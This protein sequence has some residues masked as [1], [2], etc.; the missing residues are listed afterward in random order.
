MA[1]AASRRRL[2]SLLPRSHPS[3]PRLPARSLTSTTR[4]RK[5][6]KAETS[7][8]SSTSLTGKDAVEKAG[9]LQTDPMTGEQLGLQD[10][11]VRTTSESRP[12]RADATYSPRDSSSK[13][14][15]RN[16]H[17]P[18]RHS[19]SSAALSPIICS[20]SLGIRRPAGR[21]LAFNLMLLSP[22]TPPLPSFTMRPVCSRA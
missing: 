17:L 20:A 12:G 1:S 9:R 5:E 19:S 21:L 2:S 15:Q 13:S 3:L 8:P 7:L 16:N 11:E 14:R 10:I 6:A 18:P 4:W 22:S